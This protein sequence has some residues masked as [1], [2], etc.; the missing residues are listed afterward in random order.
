MDKQVVYIYRY[1]WKTKDG[2]LNFKILTDVENVHNTF[3][4]IFKNDDNIL[5]CTREYLGEVDLFKIGY[6]DTFKTEKKEENQ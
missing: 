3:I 1:F 4:D 6:T 2:R 5:S